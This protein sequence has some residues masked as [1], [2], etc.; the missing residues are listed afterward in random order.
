MWRLFDR[1]SPR[2]NH[3][4]PLKDRILVISK[5]ADCMEQFTPHVATHAYIKVLTT[6]KSGEKHCNEIMFKSGNNA[7][8]E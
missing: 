6:T 2:E 1:L 5:C 8:Y 7:W 4:W 3:V